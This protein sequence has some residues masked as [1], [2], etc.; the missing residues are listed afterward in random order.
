[1]GKSQFGVQ[2]IEFL[3]RTITPKGISPINENVE[4][5]LEELKMPNNLLLQRVHPQ[6]I[7]ETVTIL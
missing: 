5:F 4:K 1:M 3:G 7:G 2:K 6:T